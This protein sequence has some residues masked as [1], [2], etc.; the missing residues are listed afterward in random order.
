MRRLMLLVPITRPD[1]PSATLDE[2]SDD[3]TVAAFD[4]IVDTLA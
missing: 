2:W 3:F 4:R 1:G